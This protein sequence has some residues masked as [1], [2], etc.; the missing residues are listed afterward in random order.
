MAARNTKCSISMILRKNRGLWTVYNLSSTLDNI[1]STV[2]ILPSTLD[3]NLH[4]KRTYFL[5]LTHRE[6]VMEVQWFLKRA[7]S[8]PQSPSFLGH[9]VLKREALEAD[10]TGCPKIS[11]IRS[12]MSRS[13][14]YQQI[15]VSHRSTGDKTS[16]ALP[17][18]WLL[19]AVLKIQTSLN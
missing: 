19:W 6:R 12:R 8:R 1:P 4:S 13:Y 5:K 16:W 18:V 3:K 17:R 9:V 2:D 7:H 14:K 15:F 11:D 10:V